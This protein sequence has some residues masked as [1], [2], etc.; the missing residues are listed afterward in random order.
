MLRIFIFCGFLL[1]F[2]ITCQIR[3]KIGKF[4][5]KLNFLP[6]LAWN[7]KNQ[8][9]FAKNEKM[10]RLNRCCKSKKQFKINFY[11]FC[12][13]VAH[14]EQKVAKNVFF[15]IFSK[16]SVLVKFWHYQCVPCEISFQ[17]MY[18]FMYFYEFVMKLCYK[19]KMPKRDV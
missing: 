2:W 4:G 1:I 12:Q 13:F 6:Y 3:S 17:K 10:Q 15:V 16:R 19:I 11:I 8:Q 5:E 18:T 9:N 14:F 7:S